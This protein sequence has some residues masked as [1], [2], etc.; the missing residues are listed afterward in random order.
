MNE[1]LINDNDENIND[2]VSLDDENIML[3]IENKEQNKNN[4]SLIN[5]K[6]RINKIVF[7]THY[8]GVSNFIVVE[9][10]KLDNW[11]KISEY[12][13]VLMS[14][15][16]DDE[17]L[18]LY[19]NDI[20]DLYSLIMIFN[21]FDT[22]KIIVIEQE[23]KIKV[24]NGLAYFGINPEILNSIKKGFG[25]VW[26]LSDT[27]TEINENEKELKNK[28]NEIKIIKMDNLSCPEDNSKDEIY[29]LNEYKKMD[30]NIL[31]NKDTYNLLYEKLH[32]NIH[33]IKKQ[34]EPINT[35]KNIY[36]EFDLGFIKREFER[37]SNNIFNDLDDCIVTGGMVSKHFTYNSYFIDTDYDVFLFTKP[38]LSC[39][40]AETRALEIIKTLYERLS[41]KMK[42]YIIKTKNTITLYNKKFEVQIIT[43]LYNNISDIFTNFDLDCC[44]V[45]YS[46]GN[47][48]GLPRFIRSLAYSG[49]IFDPERQSSSYIHRLKKY[50]KR[51]FTLYVPGLKKNDPD[52]NKDNY[53]VRKMREKTDRFE[54][55]S[56]Y[57][58]FFVLMKNRDNEQINSVLD[59]FHKKNKFLD[60]FEIKNINY[61]D[62]KFKIN[63]NTEKVIKKEDYY[64]DMYFSNYII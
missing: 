43:K 35:I 20:V 2:I 19:L 9:K 5:T 14:S 16:H 23:Y 17:T 13:D 11:R 56:D 21:F 22:N 41:S 1:N 36:P 51:D 46:K 3:N 38:G 62:S 4:K 24:L 64:K 27:D 45:G 6:K 18:H 40:S 59:N 7:N 58:D 28:I 31:L 29:K 15:Y 33:N 57:C 12:I 53:I 47:L 52:Y 42:T 10:N 37:L 60:T 8:Y 44:C 61:I 39:E 34:Y 63:W 25:L 26:K 49:N 50:V 55:D 32:E 54:K 48:Y 30:E